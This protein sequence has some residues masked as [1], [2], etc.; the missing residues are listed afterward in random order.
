M[1]FFLVVCL[2]GTIQ[3]KGY[4][5]KGMDSAIAQSMFLSIYVR[6]GNPNTRKINPVNLK[7]EDVALAF[8]D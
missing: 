7:V 3:P 1:S 6:N 8:K 4:R 2:R 5:S